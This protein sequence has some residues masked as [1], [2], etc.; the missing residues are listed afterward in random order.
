MD[1]CDYLEKA[2]WAVNMRFSKGMK[3]Q[4]VVFYRVMWM[5]LYKDYHDGLPNPAL[6]SA[7]PQQCLKQISCPACEIIHVLICWYS[8]VFTTDMQSAFN[9]V[10]ILLPS[11]GGRVSIVRYHKQLFQ[12]EGFSIGDFLNKFNLFKPIIIIHQN[13]L[14]YA[15]SGM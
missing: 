11:K 12:F 13:Q 14:I 4:D 15:F 6:Q 1:A 10:A 2:L 7:L 8:I 9:I 5:R 3:S